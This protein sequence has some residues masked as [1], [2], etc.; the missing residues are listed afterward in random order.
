VHDPRELP[1]ND[2][3][4]PG[5]LTVA[6]VVEFVRNLRASVP[7]LAASIT[8][9]DPERDPERRAMAAVTRVLAEL[10]A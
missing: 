9:Y 7:I 1:A 3:Q 4:T 2:Y 8:A 5:G 10:R 6:E